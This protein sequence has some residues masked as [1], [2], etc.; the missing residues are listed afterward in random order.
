M[1]LWSD[2]YYVSPSYD[3]TVE[4]PCLTENIFDIYCTKSFFVN[5][6]S[7]VRSGLL[8]SQ[9]QTNSGALTSVFGGKLGVVSTLP[10]LSFLF[11]KNTDFL[12]RL[13]KRSVRSP[14]FLLWSHR[15]TLFSAALSGSYTRRH[16]SQYLLASKT[17]INILMLKCFS[18]NERLFFKAPS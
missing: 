6:F 16:A 3:D 1:D 15:L 11:N 8:M 13:Q 4:L 12:V 2:F 14:S 7:D 10:T 17:L 5:S 18:R 9:H